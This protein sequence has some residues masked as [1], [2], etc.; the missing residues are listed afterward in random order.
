MVENFTAGGEGGHSPNDRGPLE[1]GKGL[2][3]QIAESQAKAEA[4]L[5]A[6]IEQSLFEPIL[7][8]YRSA[9]LIP[10]DGRE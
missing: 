4:A 1:C 7:E 2:R 9:G 6:N 5:R 8:A 10:P 3:E